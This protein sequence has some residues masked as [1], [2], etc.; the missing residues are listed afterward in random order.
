MNPILCVQPQ[1]MLAIT[2]IIYFISKLSKIIPIIKKCSDN[3]CTPLLFKCLVNHI[4]QSFFIA[5]IVM[6]GG[7]SNLVN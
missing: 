5:I 1:A 4:F 7:G 2:D 3:I 6:E